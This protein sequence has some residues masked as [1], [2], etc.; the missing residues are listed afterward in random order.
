MLRDY[1]WSDDCDAASGDGDE[2]V[3]TLQGGGARGGGRTAHLD[4]PEA[5]AYDDAFDFNH[6][7]TL[8]E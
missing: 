6:S 7:Y 2:C 3:G 4:A 5:P 8:S 1:T